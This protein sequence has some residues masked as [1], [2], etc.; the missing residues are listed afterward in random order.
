MQGSANSERGFTLIELIVVI[1]ILGI[2]AATA[3]PKFINMQDD[4]AAAAA[5]GVAG[6]LS[7]GS[8][9][10]YSAAL[11]NPTAARV[12][13]LSG[14]YTLANASALLGGGGLPAGY[15]ITAAAATVDCGAAYSTT[16]NSVGSS[17]RVTVTGSSGTS[18]SATATLICTG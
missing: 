11:I 4:A 9:V 12:V 13:R 3:L 16:G 18:S 8:A 17:V 1:V 14:T 6:A 5:Q 2:L 7:S 10:N 15:T